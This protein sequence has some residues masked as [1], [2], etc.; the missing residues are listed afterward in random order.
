MLFATF[1]VVAVEDV[2]WLHLGMI[3]Q[4]LLLSFLHHLYEAAD[5]EVFCLPKHSVP[6]ETIRI[7][8]VAGL[9]I[10]MVNEYV[11]VRTALHTE[12]KSFPYGG[13]FNDS[14]TWVRYA[15]IPGM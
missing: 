5:G 15:E 7:D 14:R 2:G 3:F 9:C 13:D 1:V 6:E 4:Q 12:R 10:E 11:V 8:P